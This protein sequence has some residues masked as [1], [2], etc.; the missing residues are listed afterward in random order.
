MP[1]KEF[2]AAFK[3]GAK[4]SWKE[5]RE[6][7]QGGGGLWDRYEEGEYLG[8]TVVTTGVFT[9]GALKDAEYISFDTTFLEGNYE[10]NNVDQRIPFGGP[11]QTPA[12]FEANLKK[13]IKY[14][15]ALFP[16]L[17]DE[18]SQCGNPEAFLDILESD[19]ENVAVEH[20]FTVRKYEF[21]SNGET[22]K[23]KTRYFGDVLDTQPADDAGG[24]DADEDDADD[25]DE[26]AEEE[27]PK[28]TKRR[29]SRRKARARGRRSRR[30]GRGRSRRRRRSV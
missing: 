19:I 23:G 10:G 8:S 6:A 14:C 15:K 25:A 7:E 1:R 27:K 3:Q 24:D 12:Q 4:K 26:E 28:A 9:A 18:I 17:A 5:S 20:K 11:N 30:A 13:A 16:D 29:S 2:G 21:E 22:I